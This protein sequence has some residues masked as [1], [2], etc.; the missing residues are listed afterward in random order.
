VSLEIFT[1]M[2]VH[3]VVFL[4]MTQCS[5]MAGSSCTWRHNPEYLVMNR[6]E[7][8]KRDTRGATLSSM[9]CRLKGSLP[10]VAAY[11][12]HSIR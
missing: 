11:E 12:A 2:K 3:V 4:V 7:A 5:D 10:H 1:A 8:D 6:I 9:K